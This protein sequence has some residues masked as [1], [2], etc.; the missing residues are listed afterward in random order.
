MSK[1]S[2][3]NA[4]EKPADGS[5]PIWE[6]GGLYPFI[7]SESDSYTS[8]F[9]HA[10][11]AFYCTDQ[12]GRLLAVSP[13]IEQIM[14]YTRDEVVGRRMLDFIHANDVDLVKRAY[15]QV[16]AG[17][18]RATEYRI[19]H[20]NGQS[21]WVRT[22][23]RKRNGGTAFSGMHGV[24]VDITDRM[25]TEEALRT[26]EE[27]YRTILNSIQEGYFEVDLKGNVT[28]AN[29]AAS[30]ITGLP[31]DEILGRNFRKA[32]T[33][34]A[35]ER[36]K[37]LFSRLY[38]TGEPVEIADYELIQKDGRVVNLEIS[39]SI[40]RDGDGKPSG[41][42]GLVRDITGRLQ[43]EKERKTLEAQF[44]QAQKM[45]AIGTLVGSIAHDFNNVLMGILE[46]T[47]QLITSIDP[48]D[49]FYGKIERIDEFVKSGV[50]LTRQLLGFARKG[51]GEIKTAD[52]SGII[53]KT[54]RMFG[55]TKSNI[56][57]YTK[58]PSDIWPV[59]V[60]CGQI[61][62]VLLN[63]YVNSWQ[64]MPDGGDLNLAVEN[65][66]ID[67]SF[68]KPYRVTPG[69]YVK[70]SVTDTGVGIDPAVIDK[71]FDPFFTTK[72]KGIGTGLGLASAFGIIKNHDGFIDVYSEKGEGTTFN[73]Y[74]PA[75]EDAGAKKPAAVEL[76]KGME[77]VLLVDDEPQVISYGSKLL[78]KL[79]YTVLTAANGLETIHVY[80]ANKDLIDLVVLDLILPDIN[81][82]DVFDQ[83][84]EIR[85]DLPVLLTSGYHM[86]N[87]INE[88]LG[89]GCN[90]FVQ[91]PFNILSFSKKLREALDN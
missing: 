36:M 10:G 13:N 2:E 58:N 8:L 6:P 60:D 56:T 41:F 27:R 72:E 83:L 70:T 74:L 51:R 90:G 86:N 59:F 18:Y 75:S 4:N 29:A 28:F 30:Q 31:H 62:Q 73:F 82:G 25:T 71:I 57:I 52:L 9:K 37:K 14:G 88:I 87:Q 35:I 43:A 64:A 32:S 50:L 47:S 53:A 79:G 46:N 76:E 84:R 66:I 3:N 7:V 45:Q 19:R 68:I 49:P 34:A 48:E 5:E 38:K 40:I 91:K 1:R 16:A 78:G 20:R 24:L 33:G 21:R 23:S 12:E 22:V 17:N 63:L 15:E 42:R 85:S 69:R 11:I 55:Q 39:A 89:R 67:D 80:K 77:T 44:Y 81:G 54:A 26:S 61:E 65:V